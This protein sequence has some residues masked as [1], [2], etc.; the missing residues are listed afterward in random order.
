LE[1]PGFEGYGQKL[2]TQTVAPYTKGSSGTLLTGNKGIQFV[3]IYTIT[4]WLRG[5]CNEKLG[6]NRIV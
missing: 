3:P 6:E 4:G 1:Y 2:T 5:Y